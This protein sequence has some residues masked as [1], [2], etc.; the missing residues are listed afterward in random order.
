MSDLS[1]GPTF[2]FEEYSIN[3]IFITYYVVQCQ[4]DFFQNYC[5][6]FRKN[7]TFNNLNFFASVFVSARAPC[8]YLNSHS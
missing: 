7:Q 6:F 8:P 2:S 5:N 1:F 4:I 3:Y